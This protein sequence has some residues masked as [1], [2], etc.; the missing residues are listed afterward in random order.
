M[1]KPKKGDIMNLILV[2][3]P[4]AGKGTQADFICKM[5]SI[6]HISTGD[7][8]RAEMRNGTELGLAA[9]SL[10]EKGE[11]VSDDIIIGMVKNRLSQDD[12]A[13]GFLLDGF[14]RT[15]AQ[16]DALEN[17]SEIEHVINIDVPFEKLIDRICGRRMC[18]DCGATYHVSTYTSDKCDKCGASLYQRDD[19]KEETVKN[20]LKVYEKQTQPLIDYYEKKG[21]LFTVDGDQAIELVTEAIK[22]YLK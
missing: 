6:P 8:L 18:P 2:G 19:D 10:I 16:A 13:N 22:D 7:M 14:P 17:I 11:L 4:G 21:K 3:P 12:C 20:R 9:K 5:Y 15:V 1:I